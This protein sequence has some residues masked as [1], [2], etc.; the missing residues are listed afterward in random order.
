MEVRSSKV[1]RRLKYSSN[2]IALAF[3]VLGIL[4][5]V[6]FFFL[7]HFARIDLTQDKRYT[8]TSSTKEVLGNLDDIVTIKL[9]FSKNIPSYLVNLKRNVTDFLDEYRAYAG[10][11]P[12]LQQ[13]LRFMGI[14]QV[15]LNII[16]KDQAQLTNVYLGMAIFYADKKEVIPFISDTRNLEYDL[17]SAVVKVTRTESKTV[18]IFTGND[19]SLSGDY[20]AVKQLL[21]KQY[22]LQ[23]VTLS[24]GEETLEN[25]HTLIVA[26][27]R[28]PTDK[29]L[30]AIDQFLM[31]GGKIVF[32]VDT[33]DIKEG[34]QAAS[35]KPGTDELIQHYGVKV[36][37]NL[38]LDRA[39][40]NAAFRSGFM[41]FRLPYPYW[42]KVIQEGFSPDNP[43]VSNLE[44]LVLPWTSAL[45]VIEE[46][47]P[48]ITVTELAKSTPLSW[49]RKG[50][51]SL[52]PQQ[53]FL[54]PGMTTE[55]YPLILSLSG[56]FTSFFADKPV[57]ARKEEG[58]EKKIVP[59]QE[60][61]KE[62]PETQ[63]I[64]VGNSRFITNDIITQFQDNQVFLLNITDWL[65]LGEQLIGI[66]SR[67]ATDRPL[68]E[69]TE[70]TKTL[71]K[72]LNM[73]AVPLLLILFGLVRFYLRRRKK[74]KDALAW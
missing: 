51:Y 46:K 60:T 35:F 33:V 4:A 72:F 70:Y 15:Q 34:L 40:A 25:I 29:Q 41:T 42:V 58:T 19:H 71:I 37:E 54:T 73:F 1:S 39:N 38:V 11:N 14:P 66:R 12:A 45:S 67:G 65:T 52:D 59:P 43:A 22:T 24:T 16:E 62:S 9:Y 26:G 63:I 3:I 28:E 57:P 7:R 61:I 5:V 2:F 32:L 21:E 74:R 48:A 47:T 20:Q 23:E 17:T 13:E 44:S 56:T 69:T 18:G 68:K 6:N 55:S 8:L 10:E 30:Y 50:F 27:L 36:E 53:R 49:I 64:V 31:R